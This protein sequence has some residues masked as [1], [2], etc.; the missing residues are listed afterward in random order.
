MP[1]PAL[2]SPVDPMSIPRRTL[3]STAL[4]AGA[5]ALAGPSRAQP[6]SEWVPALHGRARLI[7]G[8]RGAQGRLAGVEIALDPGFKTYWREP[9][10]SGLPP[11]LDWSSS[12]NLAQARV[13]WPA[14]HRA[15]DGG[16]VA[17]GYAGGTLLPVIV[18]AA[19][20]GKPVL[21][22]LA[23]EYGICK[24]ICIPAKGELSLDLAPMPDGATTAALA[25]ALARVPRAVALGEVAE[26][27]AITG[28]ALRPGEGGHPV[29]AVSVQAPEGAPPT[30]F[31]E[32]PAGFFLLPPAAP[33]REGGAL[34]F[35]VPVLE[36]PP[37][38]PARLD[39]TLTL[40]AGDGRAIETRASLD[41]AD[42]PR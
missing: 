6:A 11:V 8:G 13:A 21:L 2:R 37:K 25:T 39:L 30:L 10:E 14:P 35:P 19:D 20:P 28:L 31:T 9:G 1:L 24:D 29:V 34:V 33:G 36:A 22:R 15:E 16:G 3:L 7:D 12:E 42:W 26:G 23:L 32:A 38:R 41:T 4:S 27:L 18:A 5:F 40:T 17:Y